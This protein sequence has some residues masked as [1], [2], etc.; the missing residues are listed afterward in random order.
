MNKIAGLACAVV[1]VMVGT[2]V[3]AAVSSYQGPYKGALRKG[4]EVGKPVMIDFYTDWCGWC[5]VLDKHVS[6][7]PSTMEKFVYYRVNAERDVALAKQFKVTGYPTIVFV[8]PDGSEFHRWSGTPK[9]SSA[10]KER[11]E[12][13]AKKAGDIKPQSPEAKPPSSS[14]AGAATSQNSVAETAAAAAL[15]TAQM[16]YSM[17]RDAD[18]VKAFRQIIEKYPDTRAAAQAQEKLNQAGSTAQNP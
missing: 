5:K 1:T 9:T 12:D 17:G 10:L 14:N 6:E 8:K 11:L 7:I 13:I 15:R 3:G 16:S 4:G 18:A 2:A